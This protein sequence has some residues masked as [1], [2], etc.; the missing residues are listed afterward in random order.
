MSDWATARQLANAALPGLPTTKAG[1]IQHVAKHAWGFRVVTIRGGAAREYCLDHLTVEQRAAW[2][3]HSKASLAAARGAVETT[4]AERIPAAEGAAAGASVAP[5]DESGKLSDNELHRRA[6]WARYESSPDKSKSRA[7]F[8][9]EVVQFAADLIEAQLDTRTNAYAKASRQFDV[10][11]SAV[12][13]WLDS[14]KSTSRTDWLAALVDLHCGRQRKSAYDERLYEYWRSD[15]LRTDRPPAMACYRRAVAAMRAQGTGGPF[16]ICTSL[17]RRLRREVPWRSIK[18]ARE[19]GAALHRSYPAQ[20]RDRGVFHALE[21]VNGD[22][23]RWN[24]PIRWPDGDVCRPVMW[25]WQDVYSG[26]LLAYRVD[27]TENAGL[28]R[29]TIGDLVRLEGIPRIFVLDSTMAAAS[30]WITGGHPHR[31]RFKLSRD[32]PLGLITLLG[33]QLSLT[34]PVTGGPS[35]PIERAWGDLDRD[36]ARHP[37]FTGAHLGTN[38]MTRPEATGEPVALAKF[39]DV[40]RQGI[41]DHNARPGRRTAVCNGRSFDETY[42]QSYARSAVK[43]ATPEQLRLCMLAAENVNVAKRDGTIALFGNLYYSETTATL[44]GERV[45]VRFD[46]E[47]LQQSVYIYTRDGRF[48]GEAECRAAVGFADASAAREHN[49]LRRRN[50]KKYREIANN[51][52]CMSALQLAAALPIS[53]DPEPTASRVV[54]LFRPKIQAPPVAA[55]AANIGEYSDPPP[56]EGEIRFQRYLQLKSLAPDSLTE[57]QQ[58]YVRAFEGSSD[59]RA[60]QMC[61]LIAS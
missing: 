19:G 29:L 59:Y 1:L 2:A 38:P 61:G 40:L 50:L 54:A 4:S 32:D 49:K 24:L 47:L 18:F 16:P 6:L 37:A 48:V 11:P 23:Y 30:K 28:L 46:P 60:R 21:V 13:A 33:A 31:Y 42:A 3:N 35:K 20:R 27:K 45:V 5:P 10:S 41:L 55:A 34:T 17:L 52:R 36:I 56:D 53:P 25:G 9:L 57:Q 14:V 22:G 44:A 7:R 12:R 39:L 43:K 26:K 15:Y 8:R 58:Q 51:E